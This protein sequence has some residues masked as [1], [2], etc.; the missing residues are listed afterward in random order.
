MGWKEDLMNVGLN[1]VTL[2]GWGA[3]QA[4]GHAMRDSQSSPMQAGVQTGTAHSHG[5]N[6]PGFGPQRDGGALQGLFP[7]PRFPQAANDCRDPLVG[8]LASNR[9]SCCQR[10]RFAD[11]YLV[12]GVSGEMWR[13]N[14]R[15]NVLEEIPRR[16]SK[17]TT[18][19]R[20]ALLEMQLQQVKEGYSAEVLSQIP[21]GQRAKQLRVFEKRYLQPLRDVV[22]SP[23]SRRKKK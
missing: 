9:E 14:T 11:G 20:K 4:I 10:F 7:Q 13:L 6:I 1:I 16:S 3:G 19:A 5:F 23:G 12:D 8:S 18:E 15:D 21:S 17:A 2:G 22:A